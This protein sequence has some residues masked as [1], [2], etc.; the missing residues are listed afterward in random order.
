MRAA[1]LF[2]L[3]TLAAPLA[4]QV[5]VRAGMLH[6]MAGEAIAAFVVLEAGAE[7]SEAEIC[8]ACA[9]RLGRARVP[10]HVRFVTALPKTAS[11]KVR[12]HLLGTV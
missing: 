4:T 7:V 6:T 11:G 8:A 12:K 10:S 9:R 3:L 1:S 5:V 2:M